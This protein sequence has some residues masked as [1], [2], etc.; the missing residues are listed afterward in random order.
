MFLRLATFAILLLFAAVPLQADPPGRGL[1][2]K[3]GEAPP[4]LRD[5]WAVIVGISAYKDPAIR[6]QYADR[7]AK[8][9]SDLIQTPGGGRFAAD[10][11]RLLQNEEAT[12]DR[13]IDA[14]QSFL[15]AAKPDDF[16][17]VHF[18][19][20]GGPDS[21]RPEVIYLWPYEVVPDNVAGTAIRMDTIQSLKDSIEAERALFL[22][23]TCHSG[24]VAG[25]RADGDAFERYMEG[26][27]KSR[28]GWTTFT[29][30]SRSQVAQEDARWGGGHGVFTWAVLEGL[31]GAAAKG[32]DVVTASEL[33]EFVSEKVDTE[34]KGAQY[35]RSKG[36]IDPRL[37]LAA[38]EGRAVPDHIPTPRNT[39]SEIQA[40]YELSSEDALERLAAAKALANIRPTAP[41]TARALLRAQ[42]DEDHLV[43]R[44]AFEALEVIQPPKEV[45]RR[46]VSEAEYIEDDGLDLIAGPWKWLRSNCPPPVGGWGHEVG[47]EWVLG[48]VPAKF[49]LRPKHGSRIKVREAR[50]LWQGFSE[51]PPSTREQPIEPVVVPTEEFGLFPLVGAQGGTFSHFVPLGATWSEI[52]D[53]RGW[54]WR[55][56]GGCYV[57][58]PR[59][60]RVL[61]LDGSDAS[62]F[63]RGDLVRVDL[64][65]DEPGVSMYLDLPPELEFTSAR[66]AGVRVQERIPG[67]DAA[68][69][70]Q[71]REVRYPVHLFARVRT[72]A[73]P[74]SIIMGVHFNASPWN[75]ISSHVLEVN[76]TIR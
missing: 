20:H 58:L 60:P 54:H 12:R 53:E 1:P 76:L 66:G 36:D 15:L 46:D 49:A 45:A 10:H 18:A 40:V 4:S 48:E 31:R 59:T 71:T 62:S 38:T 9:L 35:P 29:S 11:I 63:K 23:D 25:L 52:R 72:T 64:H 24:A 67:Q 34:T 75:H 47:E 8:A 33:F 73:L 55:L 61:A 39:S 69:I 5:R 3:A 16:V 17:L 22:F 56:V 28:P 43:A 2:F 21:R 65:V 50:A 19:G 32:D 26:M 74:K 13:I 37:V 57:G 6:L 70:V 68:P 14:L 42:A 51:P 7:D 30:C 41:R 27:T 44:A